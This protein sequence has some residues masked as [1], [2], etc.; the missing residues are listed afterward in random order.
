MNRRTLIVAI[1]D[2][3]SSYIEDRQEPAEGGAADTVQWWIAP[4]LTWRI[5]TFAID[6][7]L[8]LHHVS[9][10]DAETYMEHTR[11]D[12]DG[13]VRAMHRLDFDD[14]TDAAEVARVLTEAGLRPDLEIADEHGFAFWN[15]D[16]AIYKTKSYPEG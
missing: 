16:R 6:H 7:D 15:P 1:L 14:Y 13:L 3:Q 2:I 8:H 9:G 5:R 12:F 11:E 4:G 10:G